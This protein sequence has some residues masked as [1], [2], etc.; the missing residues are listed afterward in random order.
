MMSI[1][2]KIYEYKKEEVAQAKKLRPLNALATVPPFPIRDF[3][4]AIA[5]NRP[6][7]IAEIK[8]ASPS[9]G[10][11]C[12]DFNVEAIAKTYTQH[13]AACLS[14]LTDVHFF[15]GNPSFLHVAKTH[16]SLPILRKDFIIDSYQIHESLALGADCILLIAAML[17]DRQMLDYC[18]LAQELGMSVLVESHDRTELERAL[19]LPTPLIGINN[20]SLHTFQT[21]LQQSID[22]KKHIPSNKLIVSESGIHSAVDIKKLEASGIH[23]FLIG[24]SLMKATDAGALLQSFLH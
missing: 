3:V 14:V 1:L 15:Q 2:S 17:D 7:I 8:K 5:D 24:E 18:R 6:A 10:V 19:Q 23:A 11:I 21:T 9:K 4:K 22:L 12:P 13:G 20:R 16:S